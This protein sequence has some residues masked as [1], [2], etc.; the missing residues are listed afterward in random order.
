M[1]AAREF[2]MDMWESPWAL[3][4]ELT[5]SVDNKRSVL[6]VPDKDADGLSGEP[7]WAPRD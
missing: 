2:I 4:S 3:S 1:K 6:I 7:Q 5:F